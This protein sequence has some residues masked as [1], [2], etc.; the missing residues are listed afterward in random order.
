MSLTAVLK[1]V[2]VVEQGGRRGGAHH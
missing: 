2:R 1:G